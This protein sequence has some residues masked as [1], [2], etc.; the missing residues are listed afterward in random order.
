MGVVLSYG[1][2][3]VSGGSSWT[4]VARPFVGPRRCETEKRPDVKKDI[5][6]CALLMA[7]YPSGC[8]ADRTEADG[9]GGQSSSGTDSTSSSSAVGGA[10]GM[11]SSSSSSAVGGAGG[12]SLA[13]SKTG[14][15]LVE[16]R[17]DYDSVANAMRY[18]GFSAASDPTDRLSIELHFGRGDPMPAKGPGVYT[19]GASAEEQDYATCST[20]V[21][22]FGACTDRTDVTT[23]SSSYF[24]Q[25]GTLDVT[26]TN[27]SDGFVATLTD[28][29]LV[30]VTFDSITGAMSEVPDGEVWCVSALTADAT[31]TT[32]FPCTSNNECAGVADTPFCAMDSGT[33]VE[34]VTDD[35]CAANANGP[36]CAGH[37]CGA[38]GT[39]FD[40]AS[41]AAPVCTIDG[42]SG[43]SQCTEGGVCP[44]G[45]DAAEPYDDGPAGARLLTV[46]ASLLGAVCK[47]SGEYDFFQVAIPAT[48]QLTFSLS[49]GITD[50][51]NAQ[52]LDLIVMD[53]TGLVLGSAETTTTPETVTLTAL[54]AGMYYAAV[55]ASSMGTATTAIPYALSLSAP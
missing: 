53:A 3:P 33:C 46:G 28:A 5:L 12:G 18:S 6:L 48:D 25:S 44:S 2:S 36:Y 22:A 41:I 13:C 34:C 52:D 39:S 27:N 51:A 50:P 21:V 35:D 49:F 32:P 8:T 45:D 15:T 9:S 20:C 19:L 37:L 23:C 17:A 7:A 29:R 16:Q 47:A 1:M 30:E 40:C 14:Y 31:L 43:R 54:P 4:C 10:G 55:Y 42:T 11:G 24:A 26:A 38:C